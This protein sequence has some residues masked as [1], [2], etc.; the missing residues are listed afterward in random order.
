MKILV[1]W[2]DTS[3]AANGAIYGTYKDESTYKSASVVE[4]KRI[5]SIPK[6]YEWMAS[7]FSNDYSRLF[8]AYKASE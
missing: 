1:T 7:F 6:N 3:T 5:K 2:M 8:H 4:M